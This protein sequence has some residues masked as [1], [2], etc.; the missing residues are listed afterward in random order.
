MFELLN[1]IKTQVGGHGWYV[2]DG[3]SLL[4]LLESGFFIAHSILIGRVLGGVGGLDQFRSESIVLV[5]LQSILFQLSLC[6][7]DYADELVGDGSFG[8]ESDD[9]RFAVGR[10]RLDVG[11]Q[12]RC[13]VGDAARRDDT[14]L[15][16]RVLGRQVGSSRS[17]D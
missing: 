12:G 13:S 8:V 4:D 6:N 17:H 14:Q 7:L 16:E 11:D 15:Q 1:G 3:G 9:G 5:D 2:S 10:C